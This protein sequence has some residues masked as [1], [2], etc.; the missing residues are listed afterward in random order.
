MTTN[1]SNI[2]EINSGTPPVTPLQILKTYFG[3][4]SFR[5][6]QGEIIDTILSGR[7][8]L[9]IMPTGAGKSLCYQVPALLLPG[10]TL[11]VSPLISL[12]QDQVKSLNEAGIH[13]A[14]INSSL[15]ENQI[16]KA[17]YLA[18]KKRSKLLRN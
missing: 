9:A 13:A 2:Q 3:Y 4:D 5:E 18:A 12:M 8:A 10:I 14:F 15:T 16:S 1:N 17:L 11:V 6:G 7:D